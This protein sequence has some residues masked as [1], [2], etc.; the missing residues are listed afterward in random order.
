MCGLSLGVTAA[1]DGAVPTMRCP[2]A[3]LGVS[4]VS[5]V[6]TLLTFPIY[7]PSG[8]HHVCGNAGKSWEQ[9]RPPG[10][11]GERGRAVNVKQCKIKL[12]DTPNAEVVVPV[13]NFP[14]ISSQR[15]RGGGSSRTEQPEK[16]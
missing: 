6:E 13:L 2:T 1:G 7:S 10:S 9:H 5:H 12:T 8:R 14:P 16:L 11:C 3:K 4:D 15:S